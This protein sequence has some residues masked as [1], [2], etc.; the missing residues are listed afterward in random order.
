MLDGVVRV[1]PVDPCEL[2]NVTAERLAANLNAM[3]AVDNPHSTPI[4]AAGL[5]AEARYT[6]ENRPYD[7]MWLA[8]DSARDGKRDGDGDPPGASDG[9]ISG[10]SGRARQRHDDR[11]VGHASLELPTWGNTHMGFVS[12]AVH[13][14]HRGRGIGRQLL[15]VQVEAARAAGRSMLLTFTLRDTPTPRFLTANGFDIAQLN[16]QRRIEPQQLDHEAIKALADEAAAVAA[17]YELVQLEGPASEEWLP[18]LAS[19]AEAMNDAPLDD[20][21]LEPEVSSPERL[22]DY[23]LAMAA[24]GQRVYRLLA[25][26][27]HTGEWAGQT[28]LC[29]DE[30]RPGVAMQE[31]TSVLPA[32]RGHRLGLLLKT[33]ML[34]WMR[35][36]HPELR[37]IDTW[38]ADSNTHMIEVNER[39][40]AF[41]LNRGYVLQRH[42]P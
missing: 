6:T 23:D 41:V 15:D 30:L 22:R 38:N 27:R 26:H 32:H 16:T 10:G 28:L 35:Q 3:A 40:G 11:I 39:L 19:L 1:E 17:D 31:D 36:R 25:R 9:R 29:V 13:P 21:D 34:L 2:D 7:G 42:L 20:T 33:T 24:R 12:C 14:A 4:T 5:A 8:R 18:E 37:S